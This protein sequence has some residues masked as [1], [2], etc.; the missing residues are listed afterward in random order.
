MNGNKMNKTK[1]VDFK[2]LRAKPKKLNKNV[3]RFVITSYTLNAEVN[4]NFLG[5]LNTYCKKENAQLLVFPLKNGKEEL[6]DESLKDVLFVTQDLDLNTNIRLLGLLNKASSYS[7]PTG[8]NRI[9][10]R[11]QSCV[12]GGNMISISYVATAKG[13]LPHLVAT[14]GSINDYKRPNVVQ[15]KNYLDELDHKLGA[16]IIEIE[17]KHFFHQR[18]VEF[19]QKTKSFTDLGTEY[20]SRGIKKKYP[21][22]LVLGDWHSGST[23]TS[24]SEVW[25]SLTK[26]LKINT[27][28]LHDAFDGDSINHHEANNSTKRAQKAEAGLLNLKEELNFFTKDIIG[29]SKTVKNLVIVKSNH[30]EF[31]NRYLSEMRYKDEPQNL[32]TAMKMHVA[33]I[34]HKIDPL[35]YGVSLLDTPP[36]NIKWLKRDE[37]YKVANIE[38]GF[39]GDRGSNGMKRG[40]VNT[41]EQAYGKSILGHSHT[42]KISRE[43][44]IVGT[45]TSPF[46]DYGDGPNSWVQTSCLV[47][48]DG[49][50]QLLNIMNSKVTTKKL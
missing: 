7:Q 33:W 15:K 11:G 9:G 20:S 37:S 17:D 6:V 4:H 21:S 38:L 26:S 25:E 2:E 18:H 48:D 34:E 49:T 45:T 35:M 5:A 40:S 30:D 50:R 46:P 39:H 3:K 42:P 19:N 27:W 24:A 23:D 28:V 10:S 43:V 31:L 1:F 22:H 41:F 12:V 16:M 13:K 44:Y 47:Y 32:L 14:P 29:V 36:K 8:L